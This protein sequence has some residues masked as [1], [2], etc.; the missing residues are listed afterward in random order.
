[1]LLQ[2]GRAVRRD[3]LTHPCPPPILLRGS[4]SGVGWPFAAIRREK[5]NKDRQSWSRCERVPTIVDVANLYFTGP[6]LLSTVCFSLPVAFHTRDDTVAVYVSFLI[7]A[8]GL[9]IWLFLW[10]LRT[11]LER[12]TLPHL[13][14]CKFWINDFPFPICMLDICPTRW[15]FLENLCTFMNCTP[16]LISGILKLFASLITFKWEIFV[17]AH[18]R[19]LYRNLF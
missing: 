2:I 8:K 7:L 3:R 13:S 12:H 11:P 19:E 14:K 18:N 4:S 17:T 5:R 1:M 15:M 16:P 6:G 9:S 10:R